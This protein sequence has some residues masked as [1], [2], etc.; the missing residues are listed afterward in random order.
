M[1]HNTIV[2]HVQFYNWVAQILLPKVTVWHNIVCSCL[3][4]LQKLWI[5]FF[6]SLMWCG[7]FIK[8]LS[9]IENLL[10]Y[11]IF[12]SI[13][14]LGSTDLA[15]KYGCLTKYHW[16][17]FEFPDFHC[18]L[19]HQWDSSILLYYC[20]LSIQFKCILTL[21]TDQVKLY[22]CLLQDLGSSKTLQK[23]AGGYVIFSFCLIFLFCTANVFF[24]F[25]ECDLQLFPTLSNIENWLIKVQFQTL[26]GPP[27]KTLIMYHVSP[28]GPW[29][30]S[31][32]PNGYWKIGQWI[33][34]TT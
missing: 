33:A 25:H 2:C 26:D 3:K 21:K 7:R 34:V 19:W 4:C 8:V 27:N 9:D 17:L 13:S 12:N 16:V 29:I 18:T 32:E 5:S 15:P 1:S 28:W 14:R 11:I 31:K 20:D 10:S 6:M 23:M 30:I 24:L 22:S